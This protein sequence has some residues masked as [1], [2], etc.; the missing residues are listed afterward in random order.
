MAKKKTTSL[1]WIQFILTPQSGK[2]VEVKKKSPIITNKKKKTKSEI[3]G[4]LSN[5]HTIYGY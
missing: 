2:R 4:F 1:N 3:S 5:F